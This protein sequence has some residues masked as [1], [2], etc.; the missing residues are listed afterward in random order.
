MASLDSS[1]CGVD[2]QSYTGCEKVRASRFMRI[3]GAI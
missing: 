1:V 2:Q 3:V